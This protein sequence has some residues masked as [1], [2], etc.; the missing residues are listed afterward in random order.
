MDVI[1]IVIPAFIIFAVG[2]IGQ[3]KIGFDR[4]SISTAAL[5]LMYPFLAFR[6]FYTNEVTIDYLYIVIFC[7]SLM[8][9]LILLVVVV[10]K[11]QAQSQSKSSA[12]VLA[13]VFMNS[14]NYGVPIILFAYGE[15]GVDYAIIMM[16]VQSLLMNTVG[17][18][19]AARGSSTADH[20]FKDS[21][22]KIARMPINYAVIL[23]LM[24]QVF[25]V[26]VPEFIMQSVHFIADATIPTIMIVLGMQL[27]S[28]TKGTVKWADLS[29]IFSIRL[30]VSPVI[31]LLLTMVMGLDPMLASI[32]IILAAM[33]TAANTT[34]YSL[35]F[36]TEP[37][38]V[39]YSTLVTTVASLI[40]VPLMLW[41]V[42]AVS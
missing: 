30:I 9:L 34:M 27:A 33:P 12:L 36:N 42:G 5:Y 10:S 3:K 21:L 1:L 26:S 40:T 37:Q 18:Y 38:L 35:Q 39:S 23:G 25:N 6:T 24:T 22:V 11:I 19:F 28:L 29:T 7:V 15:A 41:L 20:S 31:A 16:V 17:L 2:F 13:S 32:L 4:K 14:G 8:L